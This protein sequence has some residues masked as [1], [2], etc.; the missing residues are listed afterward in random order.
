MLFIN[1]LY[2]LTYNLTYDWYYDYIEKECV[3]C[4]KKIKTSKNNKYMDIYCSIYC[5]N[6][7]NFLSN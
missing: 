5:S 3:R 4:R 2:N 6:D 7:I 1:R